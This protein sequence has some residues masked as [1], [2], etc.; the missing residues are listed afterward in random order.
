MT[1][2]SMTSSEKARHDW[3]QSD[4]YVN[5]SI[6]IKNCTKETVQAE[7]KARSVSFDT[8]NSNLLNS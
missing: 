6:F 5:I 1:Q 7:I 8:A 2:E 4:E 3:Y